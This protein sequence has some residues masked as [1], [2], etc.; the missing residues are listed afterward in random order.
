MAPRF[1]RLCI[2]RLYHINYRY[3]CTPLHYAIYHKHYQYTSLH[4]AYNSFSIIILFIPPSCKECHLYINEGL[5]GISH[6]LLHNTVQYILHSSMLNRV[7]C[8]TSTATSRDHIYYYDT[9]IVILINSLQPSY[10]IM[11]MWY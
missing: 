3:Y 4:L 9:S 5:G 2:S 11:S 6:K 8:Y 7:V 10:V 1:R